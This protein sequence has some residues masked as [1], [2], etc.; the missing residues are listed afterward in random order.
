M[1]LAGTVPTPDDGDDDIIG[2]TM[3]LDENVLDE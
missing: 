3:V 2:V 1:D